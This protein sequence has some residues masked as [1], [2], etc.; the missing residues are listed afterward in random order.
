MGGK[1]GN[2]VKG[3]EG[4]GEHREKRTETIQK[5]AEKVRRVALQML[6]Q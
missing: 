6:P 1:G 5:S 4:K 3:K 2:Q